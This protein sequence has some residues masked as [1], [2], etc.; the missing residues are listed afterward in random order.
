[1]CNLENQPNETARLDMFAAVTDVGIRKKTNEDSH[2]V[3]VAY[4]PLG[5]SLFAIVCDGVGALSHGEE[6]SA[7]VVEAFASWYL[8]MYARLETPMDPVSIAK[9]WLSL[10][11]RSNAQILSRSQDAGAKMGTT[12]AAI[13]VYGD[14][15]YVA[16]SVGDSRI[17][18]IREGIRQMTR[19]HTA[20]RE[21][22]ARGELTEEEAAHDRRKSVLTRCVGVAKSVTPDFYKGKLESRDLLLLCSDG[23]IK[24]LS[25]AEIHKIIRRNY[26][27]M[28]AAAKELT[29][30]AFDTG[31]G[32]KDNTSVILMQ[33][34][35]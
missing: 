14:L 22:V 26:G 18:R 7:L 27:D 4:T 10:M 1:M 8:D 30:L 29:R 24:S 17:Y 9:S 11:G 2:F 33:Y 20:A 23:L 32:A 25:D 21:A 16:L 3:R 19:D 12:A 13:L 28:D 31:D 35:I 5:K 15:D 34:L 6:A